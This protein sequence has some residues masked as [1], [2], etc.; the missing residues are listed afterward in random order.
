MLA[1]DSTGDG[2]SALALANHESEVVQQLMHVSGENEPARAGES[3]K[4]VN[5]LP[6]LIADCLAPFSVDLRARYQLFL[7]LG[8]V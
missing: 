7:A 4:R 1:S 6:M 2:W 8:H 5:F 3:V